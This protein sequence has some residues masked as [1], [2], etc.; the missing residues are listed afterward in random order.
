MGRD[1]REENHTEYLYSV[2][3]N[4][5]GCVRIVTASASEAALLHMPLNFL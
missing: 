5:G 3:H 4:A 2:L 1:S